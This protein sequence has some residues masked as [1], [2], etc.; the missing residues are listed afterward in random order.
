MWARRRLDI[1]WLDLGFALLAC[2]VRGKGSA[3]PLGARLESSWGGDA[4]ALVCLSVR[5]GFDLL[6]RALALPRGSEVIM[7]ALNVPGMFRIVEENGLVPV[8]LDIDPERLA[9]SPDDLRRA[10]TPRSRVLVI[11]HLFGSRPDL[12]QLNEVAREHGL[13]VVEDRAQAYDGVPGGLPPECDVAMYSFGTIKTATAIGG[14]L[15]TIRDESLAARMAAMASDMPAQSRWR[16]L[17]R[18]LKYAGAKALS[19]RLPFGLL[20][21]LL[22]FARVDP[23]AWLRQTVRGF[24]DRAFLAAIRQRP[25]AP[26]LALLERR[27]QRFDPVPRRRQR[28]RGEMLATLLGPGY[29]IA[30]AAANQTY[31]L[32]PVR[33][34]NPERATAALRAHGFDAAVRGSMAV[35]GRSAG[36]EPAAASRL[37]RET[38]F[39]PL[40]AAMPDREVRRM[41]EAVRADVAPLRGRGIRARGADAEGEVRA[42]RIGK[43]LEGPRAVRRRCSRRAGLLRLRRGCPART[44]GSSHSRCRRRARRRGNS[45]RSAR[46]RSRVGSRSR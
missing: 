28:Q 44:R 5:T 14:A 30:G 26:L 17:V 29:P 46:S 4:P 35:L 2:I 27:L 43:G 25:C 15:L 1:G 45:H 34:A 20:M 22:G 31:D 12:A 11:A 33:V 19:Y 3:A 6:L 37:L 10:V 40:D 16:Y 23:D 42:G 18:L 8:P 24:D 38:V 13:V 41:A 32:V 9:P 21:R 39:L 7:S 36:G